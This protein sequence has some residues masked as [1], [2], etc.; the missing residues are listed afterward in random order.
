[1]P[2]LINAILSLILPNFALAAA[3]L[4]PPT[5]Q[6]YQCKKLFVRTFEDKESAL[7]IQFSH[8]DWGRRDSPVEDI[9]LGE[10]KEDY[11][12]VIKAKNDKRSLQKLIEFTQAHPA[13]MARL[14]ISLNDRNNLVVRS[15]TYINQQV[16]KIYRAHGL[17]NQGLRFQFVSHTFAG[18]AWLPWH[19]FHVL[20]ANSF[21]DIGG[22]RPELSHDFGIGTL[23]MYALS[24]EVVEAMKTQMSF[25]ASLINADVPDEFRHWAY[26]AYHYHF[27]NFLTLSYPAFFHLDEEHPQFL[28]DK[29]AFLFQPSHAPANMAKEFETTI[30]PRFVAR[31]AFNADEIQQIREVMRKALA[32][33]EAKNPG[34]T[35]RIYDV[36]EAIRNTRRNAR[37]LYFP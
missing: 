5:E 25:L 21:S 6:E 30:L 9:F 32:E 16:T 20:A 31:G 36:K 7:G 26:S 2:L 13:A 33:L 8:Q 22:A 10:T 12:V 24:S 27:H 3:E 14:G 28:S 19:G 18:L 35:T 17:A 1:M 15:G 34:S 11:T 23:L 4:L 29:L 37:L